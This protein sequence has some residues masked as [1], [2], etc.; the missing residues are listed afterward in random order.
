LAAA[1]HSLHEWRPVVPCTT[2][3]SQL[4]VLHGASE[5]VPAFRWWDRELGRVLT[6]NRPP[7]AAVIEARATHPA[8]LAGGGVSV[9]TLFSGG[10]DRTAMVLSRLRGRGTVQTREAVAWFVVRPDGLIR[11]LARTVAEV[12]RERFQAARQR[13]LDLRP[14]VHRGWVF[15]LLRAATNGVIRDLSTAVV[16][17]EVLRGAP[18]VYVDYVDY[19][20]VGHHA[21]MFP[22]RIARSPGSR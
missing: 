8:L 22:S 17:A 6:A 12:I 1:G 14:R 19:D 18:I 16:A 3:A 4:G 9:S 10:V 11:S 15:A 2:P 21:G 20:E 13:R 7:D 5:R